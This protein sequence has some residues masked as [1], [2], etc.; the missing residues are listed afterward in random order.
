VRLLEREDELGLLIAATDDA[1]RGEGG[2]MLVGGEAGIG[3]TALVRSL[4][5]RVHDRTAFLVGACEPLSV[6]VPLAPIRDLLEAAG[7][8][9]LPHTADDRLALARSVLGALSGRAPA[10]AVIEDAHWADPLTLDIL[11]MVARRV[12][13]T[14]VVIVV[15]FREDEVAVNP[16]LGLLLGDL[17]TTPVV[18]RIA[19]RPLSREAVRELSAGSGVD[20][21]RLIAATGGNPFLVTE[22]LAAGGGLPASVRDA[23]L[24]R[25][26]RLSR[27]AR[28][29]VDAAAVI[30][31]RLEP[32]LLHSLTGEGSDAIEEALARGV[33]V[34][35]G[36]ALGFRHEL[37]RE[38]LEAGISP[39]RRGD[40][41][42]RACAAL[43]AQPGGVDAA[44]L[45]HHA[46]L[47]GLRADAARYAALA[48]A[49]AERLG[50]LRETYLQAERALR[51]GSELDPEQRFD[52]LV[53]CSRASNFTNP[54]LED[55]VEAARAAVELADALGDARRRGQALTVLS[56]A[57][58]S[59]ERVVEAREAAEAAV[60]AF[61]PEEDPG[62][63]AWANATLIRMLATSSDPVRALDLAPH[64]LALADTAGLEEARLDVTISAGLARGHRG[65]REALGTL[66]DALAAAKRGGFTIRMVRTFVNLTTVAVALRD[67][68]RVDRVVGEALPLLQDLRV[69]ALPIM[70]IR[71]FRAR[72]LLDRGRWDEALA[73]AAE[74]ERW[75]RGEFPVACAV[76]GLIR[77]RRGEP[78]AAALLQQ[79]WREIVEL[80]PA[81]GA[82]HGMIRLALVEA[83]W[84]AGDQAGA[85]EQLRAARE[86]PATDRFARP[87]AELALWAS[88]CGVELP[89]PSGAPE[90]VRLELEGDW[91]GAIRAWRQLEAPYEAAL[92]ALPGDDRAA[93][94]ALTT[95]HALGA[96]AAVAAFTRARA[97]RGAAPLRG[98]RRSTRAHP[99][100][101]TRRE[102][103]VLE[104]VATGASNVA[105]A[106]ALH[107][108]ERTVAHHVSAILAKLDAPNRHIAVERARQAGLVP[109]DGPPVP[110]R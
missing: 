95:L 4:R 100:G 85:L 91:R 25:A 13:G 52:L 8:G 59:L 2:V 6:P 73:I 57:L 89:P 74:R 64:A 12:E 96:G 49:D 106:H 33:L 71:L 31:Q 7:A 45:A 37:I 77:A 70:A 10:V 97:A 46:E 26:G 47:G 61:T 27:A 44:R 75:W 65:E 86:S 69:S 99:A 68:E 107:L 18:R 28:A 1:A 58:W 109:Q 34:A 62:S 79:A 16:P 42:A 80:V 20:V 63:L 92:A 43:A 83:A 55:A 5:D 21:S 17:A 30:G 50:A 84:L 23:A 32:G 98:P 11:G 67:H 38:A 15:T 36:G 48:A 35:D 108:S 39:P 104:A 101:L 60:R 82:R 40:L 88:R 110:P 24:A 93:R 29:V 76:E 14:G 54:R 53:Q 3:K 102:Q 94:E 72:S 19:L 22:T 78:G 81:E 90:P 66:D 87:G 56:A 103:E 51:L 9:D 41:H 105:V